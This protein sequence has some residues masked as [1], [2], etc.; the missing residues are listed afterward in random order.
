MGLLWVGGG[1]AAAPDATGSVSGV[2]LMG[3]WSHS[4]CARVWEQRWASRFAPVQRGR[5]QRR[6][7]AKASAAPRVGSVG[8]D[9]TLAVGP[10]LCDETRRSDQ[11]G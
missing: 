7:D 1:G 6:V 2:M 3:R 8:H 5:T 10:V 11:S 9:S 4:A